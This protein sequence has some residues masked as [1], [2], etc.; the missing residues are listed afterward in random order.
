M[1]VLAG[2]GSLAAVGVLGWLRLR[3]RALDRGATVAG[4]RDAPAREIAPDVYL[5]GPW[6]R[7]QTNAYLVRAGSSWFLVDAGW[8]NDGPRIRAAARSLLGAGQAP[9][10]I[11][12]THVH[13]DHSG[14]ARGLA[15]PGDAPSS[16]TPPRSR[17][18][19]AI[20]RP[21]SGLPGRWTAG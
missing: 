8:E 12:L 19:P 11:L 9:T 13:P 20:S 3:R 2:A 21:W 6:G 7:T 14:S 5:L 18:R 10:A 1:W 17:S 16:R 15:G 4:G